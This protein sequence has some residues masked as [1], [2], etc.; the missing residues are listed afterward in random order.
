MPIKILMPALSPTMTE[1]TLAKWNK[2]EGDKIKSGDI[3]AE[4]ETD[5][6]TMEYEATEDGVL[7][8]ILIPGGTENVQVNTLIGI[9]LEEGEDKASIDTFLSNNNKSASITSAKVETAEVVAS[10]VPK[11]EAITDISY[12]S[13]P[14][15]NITVRD[16]LREAITEE[17]EKDDKV[18]VL[19]EEVGHYQGA[20][21]IT[22]GLL[23]K[24]GAD[25]IIDTPITEYG[26]TGMAVGAAMKGLRPIVEYM[27]FSF[28]LQAI[29]HIINSAAKTLYMSGGEINSPVVFRGLNGSGTRVAAQHSQCFASMY[30]N[31]PG[32][33]VVS[34]YS[35]EDAKG[36]LK[37]AIRN[38]NP[39][40]FL[41]NEVLYGKSFDMPDAPDLILPIG[42]A[43]IEREG[44]DVT[45]VSY[46]YGVHA[47]LE[48]AKKLES[49]GISAEV[50]NL[51]TIRPLDIE[52]IINSVKKT[53]R[54]ISVEEGWPFSG[55]GAEIAAIM[56]E[57]AFDYLDAPL[58]RVTGKDVPIPYAANLEKLA[59][60]AI[61]D[62][63]LSAKKVCYK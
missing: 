15:R 55:I 54:I 42:K 33:I 58:I 52:T 22:Q 48:A 18:L 26:F 34:P 44:S 14:L 57:H 49:E 31:I 47:S 50:V 51:R 7:G 46:S 23:D 1:G 35:S 5:K 2:A 38:N 29:D 19:G 20:Y 17:M 36:L 63:C 21:K 10:N 62:I 9:M 37:A 45:I 12:A 27:N 41:E 3:I 30:A 16:A 32:L 56:M 25:R 4:I 11:T 53:N 39:V 59:L 6:A 28:S 43:K 8:K 40:I 61:E 60:L 13:F 24:F